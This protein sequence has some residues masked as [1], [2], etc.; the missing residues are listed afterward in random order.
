MEL[1]RIDIK[2]FRSIQNAE[3]IFN[4]NC[5]ILLGKNEAGKSNVLKAIASVFGKYPVSKSDKRKR[6]GGEIIE[7][8]YVRAIFKLSELDVD[9]IVSRFQKKYSDANLIKFKNDKTL[10]DYVK[11]VFREV[12]IQ[13]NL[14]DLIIQNVYWKYNKKD[15]ELDSVLFLLSNVFKKGED[16]N[17]VK[18][19]LETSVWEIANELL[20][21]QKFNCHYWEYN[22][23]FLLPNKVNRN[24]FIADS[25]S[26]KGLENLFTMCGI[27]N[28]GKEFVDAYDQDG[29]YI[30]FLDQISEKVTSIF[31]KAWGDFENTSIELS[32][33][34]DD[35]VIKVANKVKYSFE[36]RS[37]GFKKYISILLMLSTESRSNRINEK[38]LILID[39]P[40]QSLY[41]T[42]ATYLKEEL[43]EISKKSKIIYSTHSQ[44]MIDSNC[45]DRHIIVEKK[46]DITTL[47]S[48]KALAPF[49]D[50]ELLRRA[51]GTS[52]FECL[53]PKNIIFEGYL[54]RE[55]F[56]K[57]CTWHKK[58]ANFKDNGIVYLSGISGVESLVQILMLAKK[59]FII[60]ADSDKTSNDRQLE[61][62]KNYPDFKKNWI[63]YATVCDTISTMEDFIKEEIIEAELKKNDEAFVYDKTK[64]AIQNIEKQTGKENEKKREIK[65]NLIK[66]LKKEQIKEDY[67]AYLDSLIEKVEAL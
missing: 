42:S 60:V 59:K 40:D 52:I 41:P 61:F 66:A 4:H 37:D 67:G 62:A 26:V 51:I 2:N 58:T 34:G 9:E 33:D 28:I 63:G 16:P 57:Y 11:V 21:E 14:N 19:N 5:L 44:Y 56:N 39:E 47:K 29:D 18:F 38:D 13:L 30:N 23:G 1:D 46:D 55:L 35:I 24:T 25:S 7:K 15:F 36:D 20:T 65:N 53:K 50:D 8:S 54:D 3:I 27:T 49:S 6:I 45:I 64:N 31:R 17:S 48:E 43:L 10:R 12:L 32:S 22:K